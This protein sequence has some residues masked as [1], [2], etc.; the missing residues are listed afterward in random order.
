MFFHE[1]SIPGNTEPEIQNTSTPNIQYFYCAQGLEQGNFI[2]YKSTLVS[3]EVY[4]YRA[5]NST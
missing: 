4:E 2:P 3:Q 1:Y 5:L